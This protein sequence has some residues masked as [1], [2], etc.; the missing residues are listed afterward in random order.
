MNDTH[1]HTLRAA[2]DGGAAPSIGQA[3]L[4]LGWILK[5]LGFMA[6][7]ALDRLQLHQA[8]MDMD[9]QAAWTVQL[10]RACLQLDWPQP[11]S[12][13]QLDEARLPLV[14]HHPKHRWMV[15]VGRA[16]DGL[17]LAETPTGKRSLSQEDLMGPGVLG[18]L[19]R[20]GCLRVVIPATAQ[21]PRRALTMVR[22][23]FLKYKSIILEGVA[24]TALINVVA[25]ATS[26]YSM[27]VYDRVIPSQGYQTLWMLTLGVVLSILF[28]LMLKYARSRVMDHAVVGLDTSLSRDIFARLLNVR[29]DQ[30]PQSVGSLAG[31]LRAYEGIRAL[32][33]ASTVYLLVDV[34]FALLFIGVMGAIG[35]P[36]MI[37]VAGLF[38]LV[39]LSYGLSSRRKTEEYAKQG[40][41]YSNEKT[42]LLVEAVEGAETIKAGYGGWRFLSRWIDTNQ[43]A[44]GYDLKIRHVSEVGGFVAASLQQ[45]GYAGLVAVGAW[46]VM[47]GHM[48]MGGLIAC[49]I[50][51]GR[52]FAPVTMIPSLMVQYAH[53]KAALDGL[54]RVY[55]L[56]SD[57]AGVD[58]PL[59]PA[60]V[61]GHYRFE[62]VQYAYKSDGGG[63][64]AL[65]VPMLEIKAGEKVGVL[66]PV[67][68]GK[69]TLLRLLSGMYHPRDGRILLDDLEIS[70]ISRQRLSE[71][72]GYLQQDHRLFQGSLRDNLLI[73]L[74][75]PGDDAIMAAARQTGLVALI[76]D[77][78]KGLALAIAE[79]GKGLSGGQKQLVALTRLV[80]TEPRIWLLDEPTSSMDDELERRCIALLKDKMSSDQTAVIVTHKPSILP[81]VTRLIVVV[82]HRIVLDGPR[83]A[84]LQQLAQGRGREQAA[85]AA[86]TQAATVSTVSGVGA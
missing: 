75:D 70:H 56:D 39:S 29:L 67:G 2:A 21:Q 81:L 36:Y 77:H 79:G 31:Q 48:T 42:G 9:G 17:W 16:P 57:N 12:L 74:P 63:E 33:T 10:S 84:V 11:E 8:L 60:Q 38:L 80:L 54:E 45:L 86:Q 20:G 41:K 37:V 61:Q 26:F 44:V 65:H 47:E 22:T 78:P 71:Q 64:I 83:D 32:L 49:S 40:A 55:A 13:A 43:Q 19:P 24:A 4:E 23:A 59:L 85:Q 6:G 69:S 28:E 25:L 51:S 68:S 82:Q 76:A 14:L 58:K 66:G 5:R 18:D 50:L 53:A 52:A 3:A 15:V 30:L 46:Q 62:A 72:V 27:Q 35:S 1:P 34:P 7:R 73:G